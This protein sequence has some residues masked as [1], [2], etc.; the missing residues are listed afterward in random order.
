ML[1]ATVL[2][3]LLGGAAVLLVEQWLRAELSSRR[4]AVQ[5]R[6]RSARP[7]A[8][9]VLDRDAPPAS[10]LDCARDRASRSRAADARA[11]ALRRVRRVRTGRGGARGP[12]C[13][14]RSGGRRPAQLRQ[15]DRRSRREAAGPLLERRT[16]GLDRDPWLEAQRVNF[17]DA[18]SDP[19]L[20]EAIEAFRRV[21]SRAIPWLR[22][23]DASRL[24]GFARRSPSLRRDQSVSDLLS[25]S[26]AHLFA[27]AGELS[28]IASL[29]GAPDL[30]VPGRMTHSTRR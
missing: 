5:P 3:V 28:A 12:R 6:A 30:G 16:A 14:R 29:A 20:A 26:V 2:G 9:D 24:D 25:R 18:P 19:D 1:F 22:R 23:L 4:P 13:E 8:R 15:L 27:H 11:P 7:D 10:A 17:G 21:R